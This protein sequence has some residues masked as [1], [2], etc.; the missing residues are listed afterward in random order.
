MSYR[1]FSLEFLSSTGRAA[2]LISRMGSNQPSV[3]DALMPVKD[4]GLWE[5]AASE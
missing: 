1:G 4:V 2:G 5:H 3:G